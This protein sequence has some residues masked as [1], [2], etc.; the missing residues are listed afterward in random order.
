MSCWFR[1]VLSLPLLPAI[2]IP[3]AVDSI[4]ESLQKYENDE[5]IES[6]VG[7]FK[8]ITNYINN[9]WLHNW[10]AADI[11]SHGQIHR[12]N[13]NLESYHMAL[14]YMTKNNPSPSLFIRNHDKLLNVS[15]LFFIMIIIMY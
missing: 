5:D 8:N 15:Y 1:E 12:T 2:K 4:V 7:K 9:Y 14:N 6:A 10:T 11:S 3:D 13:N